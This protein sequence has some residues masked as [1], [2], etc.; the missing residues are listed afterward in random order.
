MKEFCS[1]L[2]L[3]A[4]AVSGLKQIDSFWEIRTG[5]LL[6]ISQQIRITRM[7]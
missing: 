7:V 6:Q 4:V 3:F 5:K 2:F 1:A